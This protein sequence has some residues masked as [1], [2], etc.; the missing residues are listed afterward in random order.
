MPVDKVVVTKVEPVPITMVDVPVEY[1][2][3]VPEPAAINVVELPE[4]ILRFAEGVTMLGADG[5]IHVQDCTL[6]KVRFV[7]TGLI[8]PVEAITLPELN[9][10]TFPVTVNEDFATE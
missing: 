5:G 10:I 9:E 1:Q 4:Q 6:V 2:L 8:N 7:A 3:I